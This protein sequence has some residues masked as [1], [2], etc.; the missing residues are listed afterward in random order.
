MQLDGINIEW[1]GW[2]TFKI[3]TDMVI[4]IDP[5]VLPEDAEKADLILIT[6]EHYDHCDAKKVEQLSTEKTVIVA[7]P[8]CC[9]KLSG[10]DVR[11]IGPGQSMNIGSVTLKAVPAYNI[12]KQF[13]P[14]TNNWV[15]YVTTVKGKK[16]YHAGDTDFIPEMGNLTSEGIDIALLPCGGTYTMNIDEAAQA[17]KTIKPKIAVPMHYG[18]DVIKG[19]KLPADPNKFK[20]G[21]AP[22]GIKVELMR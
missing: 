13:H 8:D 14:K 16:I 12:G 11:K 5:Y 15:G 9:A 4:Y 2:A 21:L 1:L 22:L 3:K 6:H 17:A 18:E 20:A 7:T 10:S 19:I